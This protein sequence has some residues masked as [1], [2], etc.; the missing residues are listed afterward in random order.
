M[1][2]KI[3]DLYRSLV[4]I[5]ARYM[6]YQK[7]DNIEAVKELIPQIQEFVLWFMEENRFGVEEEV[8]QGLRNGLLQI[9]EDI[10]QAI[11]QGDKV[12][13]HDAVAYG[14]IEILEL[15]PEIRPMQEEENDVNL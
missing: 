7:R 6:I 2:E 8:Y 10:L 11:G 15:F 4:E 14:L 3:A 9:L 13:L 5:S 1:E 12:L